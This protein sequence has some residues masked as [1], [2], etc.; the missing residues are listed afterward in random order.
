MTETT[1]PA[2]AGDATDATAGATPGLV[3][4]A[5]RRFGDREALVDGDVR[6]TY[7]ELAEQIEL[8]A[9]RADRQRRRVR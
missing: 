9:R 6:L 4:D 8:V 3:R 2:R 7:A 5:A 1:D